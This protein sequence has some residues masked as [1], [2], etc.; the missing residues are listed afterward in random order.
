ME[1]DSK[2]YEAKY[3]NIY[4]KNKKVIIPGFPKGKE[5][6]LYSDGKAKD[7][8]GYYSIHNANTDEENSGSP[9]CLSENSKII[10]IHKGEYS[11]GI[12]DINIGTFFKDIIND[13]EKKYIKLI[14]ENQPIFKEDIGYFCEIK[15]INT[16]SNQ[17][18]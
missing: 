10:G 11:K 12:I 2:V 15:A 17:K 1:V 5:K 16:I 18:K 7:D 8:N 4:Y 3:K 6:M 14:M 13:F 9:I